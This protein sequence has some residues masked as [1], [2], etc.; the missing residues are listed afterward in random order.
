MRKQKKEWITF[1][2][3][4]N[5]IYA[6]YIC[7]NSNKINAKDL[8]E[9]KA[10]FLE[11]PTYSE[12]T[13]DNIPEISFK[14]IEDSYSYYI[15][16]CGLENLSLIDKKDILNSVAYD[17]VIFKV[18]KQ[19]SFYEKLR[20]EKEVFEFKKNQN[21]LNFMTLKGHNSCEKS[22]WKEIALI[23]VLLII[24]LVFGLIATKKE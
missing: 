20:N 12:S 19:N 24:A 7:F 9:I 21:G 8:V 5:I 10:Q 14:V 13:G 11:K 2:I 1:I 3:L 22:A 18:K 16:G 23:T 15:K 17:S 4:I 6:I